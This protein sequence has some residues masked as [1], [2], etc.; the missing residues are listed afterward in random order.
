MEALEYD[1]MTLQ[2]LSRKFFI[3]LRAC[4]AQETKKVSSL[5][6]KE[7]LANIKR[8]CCD[9]LVRQVIDHYPVGNLGVKQKAFLY[10]IKYKMTY[11][12]YSMAVFRFL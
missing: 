2:R 7:N 5:S 11:I 3:Y 1:E 6:R 10:M 9:D 12:L 4:I 8:I